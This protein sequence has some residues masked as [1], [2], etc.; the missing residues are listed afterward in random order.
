MRTYTVLYRPAG[1]SASPVA[2][3]VTAR[4]GAEAEAMCQAKYPGCQVVVV[5]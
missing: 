5:R 4:S 2:W 1:S 3:K